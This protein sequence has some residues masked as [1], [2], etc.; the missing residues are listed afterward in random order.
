MLRQSIILA[1]LAVCV[2]LAGC[3]G[4]DAASVDPSTAQR[5]I[6]QPIFGC[7]SNDTVNRLQQLDA[8]GDKDAALDFIRQNL[9]TGECAEFSAGDPVFVEGATLTGLTKVRPSGSTTSYWTVSTVVG[10]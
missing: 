1:M 6:K 9:A 2:L 10:Q 8:E 7:Q 4:S 5:H 3:S